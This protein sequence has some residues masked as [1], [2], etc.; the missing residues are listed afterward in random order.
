MKHSCL[1]PL[2][3]P[4]HLGL[5]IAQNDRGWASRT[6]QMASRGFNM[7]SR[8][9]FSCGHEAES[10]CLTARLNRNVMRLS[11][12]RLKVISYS[13]CLSRLLRWIYGFSTCWQDLSERA[14]SRSSDLNPHV[15][16]RIL[17]L[18]SSTR[19]SSPSL[20]QTSIIEAACLNHQCKAFC[21]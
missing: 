5:R 10:E 16:F 21:L 14:S 12:R 18:K 8:Y 13:S 1:S 3:L 20:I 17:P 6:L 9:G 11:R 19:S 4:L 15:Q 2:R 7:Q